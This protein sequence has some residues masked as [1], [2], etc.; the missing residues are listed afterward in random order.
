MRLWASALCE[1]LFV[2]CSINSFCCCFACPARPSRREQ[3]PQNGRAV[4]MSCP[5]LCKICN[6]QGGS[7]SAT[8]KTNTA[9]DLFATLDGDGDGEVTSKNVQ[10]YCAT[11]AG[12]SGGGSETCSPD[13]F[14][15]ALN[16]PSDVSVSKVQFDEAVKRKGGV[17]EM[18]LGL[19]G[20]TAGAGGGAETGTETPTG[21]EDVCS[22]P[23]RTPRPSLC[24]LGRSDTPTATSTHRHILSLSSDPPSLP[25]PLATEWRQHPTRSRLT[26]F[27]PRFF[28][29]CARHG[30]QAMT[31][32]R[33][34]LLQRAA[35]A[36]GPR[37]RANR[38]ALRNQIRA[39]LF[40]VQSG[41]KTRA[42]GTSAQGWNSHGTTLLVRCCP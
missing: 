8:S 11:L 31:C 5:V 37:K 19:G 4:Q 20:G 10:A 13:A 27:S 12:G 16:L 29:F 24:V 23:P 22:P 30:M 7:A 2:N 35:A 28:F 32:K 39:T 17:S 21:A 3:D 42:A 41:A 40:C 6:A 18:G 14:M 38:T 33:I 36:R 25:P 26:N 15:A 1:N 34:L 9:D